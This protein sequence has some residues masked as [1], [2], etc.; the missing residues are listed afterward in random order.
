MTRPCTLCGQ[1]ATHVVILLP[2]YPDDLDDDSIASATHAPACPRHSQLSLL[3]WLH[4]L[5]Q[6]SAPDHGHEPDPGRRH[7]KTTTG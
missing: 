4:G 3:E 1:P 2:T 7:Y 6:K 5:A